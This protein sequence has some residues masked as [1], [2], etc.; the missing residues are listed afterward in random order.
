LCRRVVVVL[1]SLLL[2][3]TVL[4]LFPIGRGAREAPGETLILLVRHAER[5]DD[6]GLDP[7]VAMDPQMAQDPPLSEAGQA[8]SELLAEMVRDAGI[9]HIHTTDY[10]R[11]RETAGPASDATG[12]EIAVY[13]ASDLEAFA[14]ELRSTPG[15]HLVVGHSNTTHDLVSAL[16]GDPGLPIEPLEY[17]RFYIVTIRE[18]GVETVLLRFGPT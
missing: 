11:T 10:R 18:A 6:G 14:S 5:A 16:G 7:Q 15:R 2:I 8:R 4:F 3:L 17:D 9:T 12:V 13:D 1:S